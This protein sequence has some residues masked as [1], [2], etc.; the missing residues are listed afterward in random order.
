MVNREDGVNRAAFFD[1]DGT[2]LRMKSLQ[3]FL[4]YTQREFG[5][6]L[7]SSGELLIDGEERGLTR[8]QV[9]QQFYTIF[10]GIPLSLFQNA[11]RHWYETLQ[12]RHPK[13]WIESSLAVLRSH[14][15]AGVQVILVS[16]SS[17]DLLRPLAKDLGV[18]EVLATVLE[19]DTAGSLTGEVIQPQ[20][21]GPGKAQAITDLI[22]NTEINMG[23]SFAYGDHHSDIPMLEM[24]GN[25]TV[26]GCDPLMA[27]EAQRR[28]W[29]VLRDV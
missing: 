29:R 10:R 2:L 1:V 25:P 23:S 28:G 20:M 13:C 22:R 9:N 14:Q 12:V 26:V 8:M 17:T 16:G 3:D 7:G 5:I 4:E 21:I 6:P 15:R 27:L 18:C 11:C 19:V 24:V